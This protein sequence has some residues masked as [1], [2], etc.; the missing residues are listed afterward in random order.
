METYARAESTDGLA[1]GTKLTWMV[2]GTLITELSL[3]TR[4]SQA[5]VL[6][7][8]PTTRVRGKQQIIRILTILSSLTIAWRN[9]TW[10]RIKL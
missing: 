2:T 10:L 1:G 3:Q 5:S 8:L 6:Y 9:L 7:S 4:S